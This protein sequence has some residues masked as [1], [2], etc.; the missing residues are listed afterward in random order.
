MKE[1]APE[2]S[3]RRQT[4][5]TTPHP[6]RGETRST[7]FSRNYAHPVSSVRWRSA[8]RVCLRGIPPLAGNRGRQAHLNWRGL[9]EREELQLLLL[10]RRQNAS[11]CAHLSAGKAQ[12]EEDSRR[13]SEGAS[14]SRA[15]P[16]AH[17]FAVTLA[18]RFQNELQ[19]RVARGAS[20]VGRVRLHF[21]DQAAGEHD[22]DTRSLDP[23]ESY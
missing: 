6:I 23:R 8:D 20:R 9:P 3:S 13:T 2:L 19:S 11:L 18:G 17:F 5:Q 7:A 15:V 14:R 10:T 12:P 21:Q 4:L 22:E 1:H 16:A